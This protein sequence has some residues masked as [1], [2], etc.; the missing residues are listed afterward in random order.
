ME[1]GIN[2]SSGLM[3]LAKAISR[4]NAE[5]SNCLLFAVLYKV[6]EEIA[7]LKNTVSKLFPI[8]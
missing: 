8:I 4:S 5:I 7:E 3:D 6:W 2:I 1:D